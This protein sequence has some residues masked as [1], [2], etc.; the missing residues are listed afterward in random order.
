MTSVYEAHIVV[1]VEADDEDQAQERLDEIV[2]MTD[3]PD[4]YGLALVENRVYGQPDRAKK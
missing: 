4:S 2:Q 1:N 3:W